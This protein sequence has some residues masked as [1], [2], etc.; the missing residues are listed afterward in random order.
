MIFSY[1]DAMKR[2]LLW[3][4]LLMLGCALAARAENPLPVPFPEAR[5]T[6]MSTHSPFAVA[7]AAAAPSAAPTPGF[8]AQLYADGVARIGEI[9]YV[10]IKSRDPDQQAPLFLP[11]GGTSADGLVV[12]RVNWSNEIG[13]STVDVSKGGEK[14]TL[15]FDEQ[16]MKTVAQAQPGPGQPG[17]VRLP[18]LPRNFPMQ[19]GPPTFNR[20]YPQ[21]PPGMAGPQPI[22]LPQSLMNNQ[23]RRV[24]GLIQSGN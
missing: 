3:A 18:T 16:T 6:D 8:A 15:E 23:R 9:D 19:N 5:Y 13:K 1:D 14:A 11:V 4:E 12:E 17:M 20:F 21:P 7:T 24:R 10:A 22:N 2:G